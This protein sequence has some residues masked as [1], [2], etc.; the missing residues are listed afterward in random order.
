MSFASK[1]SNMLL[2]RCRAR[3]GKRLTAE[4]IDALV[5]CKGVADCAAYLRGTGYARALSALNESNLRRRTFETALNDHLLSELY[6][7]C[8]CEQSVGDWFAD[9]II[10]RAEIRQVIAFVQLLAAGRQSEMILKT[11]DFILQ[12]SGI[13]A[14]RLA[15]CRSYDDLLEVMRHSRFIRELRALRPLPGNRPDCAL[16]E[17]AL[18]ARFYDEV[19]A[20]VDRRAGKA[21]DE[22]R[23]IIGTQLDVLNF[24]HIY[25]LKKYYG[26]D[27]AAVRAMLYHD[28]AR[29][30]PSALL[31]MVN[32]PDADSALRMFV[33]KTPYGRQLD[34]EALER[35][36]GLEPA[37]R[38]LTHSRARKL[39]RS[40]VNP[41]T[42]LLAYVLLAEAE[43]HDLTVIVEGVFYGLP[44]EEILDLIIIDELADRAG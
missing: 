38:M 30:R 14:R 36:G 26:A 8:R 9:Y 10:M 7:L 33:E 13:D 24:T 5:S 12:R 23:D 44:R 27:P 21:K 34:R 37:M 29:I 4:D 41:S 40:S 31:A 3:Y 15:D 17:H 28:G 19:L 32:A 20:L 22:L 42:V 25:R 6:A 18:Y 39:M 11:P 1:A 16:I 35:N 2:A 43:V